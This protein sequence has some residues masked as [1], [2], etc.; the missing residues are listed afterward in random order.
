MII[1]RKYDRIRFWCYKVLP[2][3]YDD[4]LSY[5]EVLSKVAAKVNEL[6]G[7]LEVS[8]EN[9]FN[10][11]ND[12]LTEW[13]NDG[14]LEEIINQNLFSD[15]NKKMSA[16]GTA[17][18]API[19]TNFYPFQ[20]S[21]SKSTTVTP[22]GSAAYYVQGFAVTPN[23]FCIV[24]LAP[25]TNKI[26]PADISQIYEFGRTGGYIREKAV[27]VHH[28]NGM[29]YYDGY[30]YVTNDTNVTKIRYLDLEPVGT[31]AL[32]GNC[33]AIDRDNKCIYSV[34][35]V[36]GYLYRYDL[37]SGAITSKQL[38]PDCPAV[39]NGSLYKDGIFYGLTYMNDFVMIDVDTGHFIGGK[40]IDNIDTF[41]IRLLELEDCDTDEDGN[42]YVLS[43][44]TM[45]STAAVDV[46]GN[47]V[48]IRRAGFYVG[49]LFL[50][51]GGSALAGVTK[52]IQVHPTDIYVISDANDTDAKHGKL[53]LGTQAYPFRTLASASWYN[54]DVRRLICTGYTNMNGGDV[55]QPII[56]VGYGIITDLACETDYP[57]A[58]KGWTG[59]FSGSPVKITDYGL[60]L[61]Y[62]DILSIDID[63]SDLDPGSYIGYLYNGRAEILPTL[64]SSDTAVYMKVSQSELNGGAVIP[65]GI[66]TTKGVKYSNQAGT[67]GSSCTLITPLIGG[68][69]G[70]RIGLLDRT[71]T[72][73]VIY[74]LY[75]NTLYGSDGTTVNLTENDRTT[76]TIK[77]VAPFT[78]DRVD[79]F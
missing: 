63:A 23:G 37:E 64:P 73:Y 59:Y 27:N 20:T 18:I 58:V 61:S 53:E 74:S 2:L 4:S 46:D 67:S 50:N 39:Y 78:F 51:G 40:H 48:Q 77:F 32:G 13:K 9:I 54:G 25:E 56:N 10:I 43:N 57:L 44:Q 16:G 6:I 45:F 14:T 49:K 12:I 34:D 17:N 3:V 36:A 38:D 52:H 42:C 71:G 72:K 79:I 68:A 62:C 11:V 66:C 41:N 76:G 15:L 33:P 24:R 19:F 70:S 31:V 60:T 55:Y 22:T 29:C 5:Y 7:A 35:S 26:D 69:R 30:L 47:P 8:E 65:K 75:G 21:Q 1:L 28:G